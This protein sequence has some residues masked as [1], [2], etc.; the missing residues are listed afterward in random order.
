MSDTLTPEELAIVEQLTA[1]MDAASKAWDE[2][3]FKL[4]EYSAMQAASAALKAASKDP[5]TELITRMRK[6]VQEWLNEYESLTDDLDYDPDDD[7]DEDAWYSDNYQDNFD[8]MEEA[9]ADLEAIIEESHP[10]AK[11]F[12]KARIAFFDA[13]RA[14]PEYELYNEATDAWS[15]RPGAPYGFG[16]RNGCVIP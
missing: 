16:S 12:N 10:L 5:R 2:A 4:P 3:R 7:D 1:D 13:E 15:D 8:S 9:V 6:Q 11:E 14:L